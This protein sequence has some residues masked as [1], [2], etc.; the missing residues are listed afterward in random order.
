MFA[1]AFSE[2]SAKASLEKATDEV[3]AETD[4]EANFAM[5]HCS[6]LSQFSLHSEHFLT[7]CHR[8]GQFFRSIEVHESLQAA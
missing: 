3:G 8:T 6:F 1:S 4:S 2:R 7:Y 5:S